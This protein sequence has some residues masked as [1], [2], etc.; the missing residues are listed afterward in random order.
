MENVET[1]FFVKRPEEKYIPPSTQIYIWKAL[2][3]LVAGICGLAVF[4]V[5]RLGVLY[6]LEFSGIMSMQNLISLGQV[7]LWLCYLMALITGGVFEIRAMIIPYPYYLATLVFASK[8]RVRKNGWRLILPFFESPVSY[9]DMRWKAISVNDNNALTSDNIPVI[10]NMNLRLKIDP[11]HPLTALFDVD[12]VIQV[13][14]KT[15][16]GTIRTIIGNIALE[17]L[18][19]R[20]IRLETGIQVLTD[21]QNESVKM[22]IEVTSAAIADIQVVDT[23]IREAI[24]QLA[25]AGYLAKAKITLAGAESETI[26][27]LREALIDILPEGADQNKVVDAILELRRQQTWTQISSQ[28]G[29]LPLVD[30]NAMINKPNS[31]DT[32]GA[33]D[34]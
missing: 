7:L 23:K 19:Q 21:I 27:K 20:K 26:K 3:F 13:I 33:K 14:N 12:N 31:P 11:K 4:S 2:V 10:L 5:F 8:R 17:S 6:A 9:I 32:G 15:V 29:L 28:G 34:T 16:E 24:A 25:E 30:L 18:S 22:G 1:L